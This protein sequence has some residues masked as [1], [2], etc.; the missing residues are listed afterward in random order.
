LISVAGQNQLRGCQCI[1]N[2]SEN[3]RADR[4]DRANNSKSG[5]TRGFDDI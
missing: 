4:T 1:G 2:K 3:I 5:R